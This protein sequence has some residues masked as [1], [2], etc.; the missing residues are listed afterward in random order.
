VILRSE[1]IVCFVDID[2]LVDQYG[3]NLHNHISQRTVENKKDQRLSIFMLCK[4]QLG[5]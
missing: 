1:V 3:L 2:G 5:K 4:L